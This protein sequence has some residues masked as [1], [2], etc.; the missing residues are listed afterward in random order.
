[1]RTASVQDGE[2]VTIEQAKCLTLDLERMDNHVLL[3]AALSSDSQSARAELLIRNIMA[4][5]EISRTDACYVFNVMRD[6]NQSMLWLYKVPYVIGVCAAFAAAVVSVPLT[7]HLDTAIWFNEIHVTADH[8][9]DPPD[10]WVLLI[11]KWTSRAH[12]NGGNYMGGLLG[13]PTFVLVTMQ[14]ARSKMYS[15]GWHPYGDYV[16]G[17]R[18]ERLVSRYP[19][20]NGRLLSLWAVYDAVPTCPSAA[21]RCLLPERRACRRAA[22]T[23]LAP[24]SPQH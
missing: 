3:G 24:Q 17:S 4:T 1:M 10:N 22:G 19:M 23:P 21:A 12:G 14:Y 9:A 11:G 2:R 18:A 6:Y 8:A 5:D 7:F 15:L 20:Y 16:R 13:T